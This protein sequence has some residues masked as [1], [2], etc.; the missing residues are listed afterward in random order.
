MSSITLGLKGVQQHINYDNLSNI[1]ESNLK[2]YYD[3]ALLSIGGWVAVSVP[4]SGAYG[5]DFSRLRPVDDANYDEG[6]VWETARKDLVWE[7]GINYVNPTGGI[8]NPTPVGLP[9]VNGVPVS[10]GYYVD[11]PNGRVIFENAQTGTVKMAHSYRY[12]QIYKSDDAPWWREIQYRSHRIDNDQFLQ[13]ASGEWSIFGT[14]RIQLPAIILEVVPRGFGK[15][16]HLGSESLE[17]SRDVLFSIVSETPWERKNLMDIFNSQVARKIHLFNSNTALNEWP[18]D[19][20]GALTGV[21]NYPYFVSS[22]GHR[23]KVCE[24]KQSLITDVE[25]IHPKLFIAT[26]R[27][28]TETIV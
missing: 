6:Q 18:L 17:Q 20:R 19:Y 8:Y 15:G 9:Q 26:V 22:S 1:L 16:W 13:S 25:Q 10:T 4:T 21:Q 28:T 12:A 14:N 3:W 2:M 23:W 7:S 27:T 11:Y 5:G 24:M